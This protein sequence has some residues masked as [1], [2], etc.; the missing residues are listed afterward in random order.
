MHY[1]CNIKTELK[2]DYSSDW[3]PESTPLDPAKPTIVFI[4]APTALSQAYSA[5]V[6][7]SRPALFT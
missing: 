5:Q 6:F 3:K 2:N 1:V 4:H 7:K